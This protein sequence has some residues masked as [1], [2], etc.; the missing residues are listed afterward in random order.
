M[1]QNNLRRTILRRFSVDNFEQAWKSA[2]RET[3]KK[4]YFAALLHVLTSISISGVDND[5][6]YVYVSHTLRLGAAA[7][8][9]WL[10]DTLRK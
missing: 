10:S 2:G 7:S 6:T 9:P 4:H 8:S 1:R 5:R 3:R